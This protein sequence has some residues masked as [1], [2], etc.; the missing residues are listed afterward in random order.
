MGL[1]LRSSH[2]TDVWAGHKVDMPVV[3]RTGQIGEEVTPTSLEVSSDMHHC[4][5]QGGEAGEGLENGLETSGGSQHPYH[6][7][8][9]SSDLGFPV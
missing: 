9:A 6:R 8:P 2:F 4:T 5:L 3:S 7:P 1:T